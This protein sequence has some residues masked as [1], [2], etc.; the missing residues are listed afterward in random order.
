MQLDFEAVEPYAADRAVIVCH[1]VGVF[2]MF[3]AID[4]ISDA[5]HRHYIK[6]RS[7]KN[8]VGTVMLFRG[9]PDTFFDKF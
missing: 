9:F 2:N 5:W 7:F 8:M 1:D 4:A 3:D 6:G